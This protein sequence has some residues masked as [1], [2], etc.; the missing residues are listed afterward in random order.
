MMHAEHLRGSS[1]K[2]HTNAENACRS[3]RT[4]QVRHGRPCM[5][6]LHFRS[7]WHLTQSGWLNASLGLTKRHVAHVLT[8][9]LVHDLH[10]NVAK[11]WCM[12]VSAKSVA[13]RHSRHRV[14]RYG[15]FSSRL[16][17]MQT[18]QFG[19]IVFFH[20]GAEKSSLSFHTAPETR[21]Q[22]P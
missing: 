15:V 7:D 11:A 5:H 20:S 22:K 21:P 10:I 9:I 2:S 6:N 12:I 1:D 13:A 4:P 3:A 18:L 8:T 17:A 14:H 16:R 19:S